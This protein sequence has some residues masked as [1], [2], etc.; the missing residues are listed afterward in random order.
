MVKPNFF[1][2]GALK[3]GTT[4]MCEY[5][6]RHPEIFI[7]SSKEI[8]YFGSD[9]GL[10][11]PRLTEEQYLE[12]HYAEAADEKMIG[13]GS[14]W[15]LYT[16]AAAREIHAFDPDARIVILLRN[17]VA[18]LY[19]LH[20]QFLYTGDEDLRD[21]GEAMAAEP[22]R[23]AG[24]RMPPGTSFPEMLYYREVAFYTDQV[25]RFLDQ[26]GPD[27]VEVHLFDDFVRDTGSV[28]RSILRFL[29]VDP[30]FTTRFQVVNPNK[31]IRNRGI[32]DFLKTPPAW[33]R[34]MARSVMPGYERRERIRRRMIGWNTRNPARPALDPSLKERLTLEFAPEVKRLETLLGRDLSRWRSP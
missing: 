25:R 18:A 28:Y 29:G 20:S 4:A 31:E 32:Q 12:W 11:V 6:G 24:R 19:S 30:G 34:K 17:P 7:P 16:R 27:Q 22:D 15:Y 9:M 2:V 23:K 1:V 26:F 8:N 33:I 10:R 5:L 13:D 3:S 14:V 21:F